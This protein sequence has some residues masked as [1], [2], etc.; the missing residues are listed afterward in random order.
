MGKF[1]VGDRV[2]FKDGQDD[3]RYEVAYV[4]SSG[5]VGLLGDH[6]GSLFSS[7][8]FVHADDDP[9][10]DKPT[11]TVNSPAHYQSE[12]GIEC[13][14]A[15]RAQLTAEEFRG[16][17]KGNIAKYVWRERTKGGDESLRKAKWYLDKL[18]ETLA[19]DTAV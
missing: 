1:K 13:I 15:I 14:E 11:D 3:S 5:G 19:D 16:Y 4:S 10:N 18:I 6:T 12:N 17:I 7:S 9:V 2:V 8:A